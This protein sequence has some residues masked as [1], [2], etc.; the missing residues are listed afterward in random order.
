M[1]DHNLVL[2]I[3]ISTN[4]R[5]RVGGQDFL[6]AAGRVESGGG[7]TASQIQSVNYIRPETRRS[8]KDVDCWDRVLRLLRA[9]LTRQGHPG[10]PPG[11]SPERGGEGHGREEGS[12]RGDPGGDDD[13]QQAPDRRVPGQDGGAGHR[14]ARLDRR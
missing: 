8:I 6:R 13:P 4:E 1:V 11:A 7:R 10:A 3:S 2:S 12:L 9:R 14:E 5:L